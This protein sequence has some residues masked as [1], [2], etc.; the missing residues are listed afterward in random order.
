MTTAHEFGGTETLQAAV[1]RRLRGIL[2]EYPTSKLMFAAH[3]QWDRGYLYRRLSGETPIDMH[4][5]DDIESCT[6]I[7]ADY[8]V[9]GHEPKLTPP[10][11][12]GGGGSSLLLPRMDSNHQP[13]DQHTARLRR[14]PFPHRNDAEAA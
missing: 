7:R 6:R 2:A 13:S 9:G 5:L 11:P 10:P 4:D 14:V 12:G 1:A 3:L 8:L